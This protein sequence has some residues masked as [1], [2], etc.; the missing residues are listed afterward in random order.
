M[1]LAS[2]DGTATA[3]L[4][5]ALPAL[6][7]VMIFCFVQLSQFAARAEVQ[8]D[9]AQYARAL[10]RLEPERGVATWFRERHPSLRIKKSQAGGALCVSTQV[11][12]A[13]TSNLLQH[14][15]WVG[16]Y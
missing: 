8:A 1:N 12:S 7:L 4:A 3:E 6:A 16:D 11:A 9:L 10:A 14:C 13:V 15:V 2:E 5:V